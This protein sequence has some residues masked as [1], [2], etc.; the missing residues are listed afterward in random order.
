MDITLP[1]GQTATF[2]DQ[3]M[4][5]D[6]REVRRGMVFVTSADGSRRTDGALVDDMTGRLIARMLVS[7]SLPLPVPGSAQ[8]E[9]LQQKILDG[10]D[11]DTYE[12]L[13]TAVQPW[14]QRIISS[15]RAAYPYTH[16]A[17]GLRV[18]FI[19][20]DEAAKAAASGDFTAI[21]TGGGG[22]KSISTGTSSSESPE[23]S[24]QTGTE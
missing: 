24:G 8:G 9:H 12:A 13:E 14:V 6:I 7:W 5:G 15:G 4:R 22:P 16:N 10:L 23:P 2:R 18:E 1:D 21:E 11:S 17:T 3:L 20:A 19:T